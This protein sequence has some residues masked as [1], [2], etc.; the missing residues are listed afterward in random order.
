MYLV[1]TGQ[2]PLPWEENATLKLNDLYGNDLYIPTTTVFSIAF[3]LLSMIKAIVYFNIA[4]I[5]VGV[6]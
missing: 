2:I 3:S 1:I 5:H 4:R 6:S